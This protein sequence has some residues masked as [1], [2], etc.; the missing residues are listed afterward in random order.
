MQST[1]KYHVLQR[2]LCVRSNIP[3][4]ASLF[5]DYDRCQ[6]HRARPSMKTDLNLGRLQDGCEALLQNHA[7][8]FNFQLLL[9]LLLVLVRLAKGAYVRRLVHGGDVQQVHDIAA[10]VYVV[11]SPLEGLPAV[12]QTQAAICSVRRTFII[13]CEVHRRCPGPFQRCNIL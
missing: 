6:L 5:D 13:P 2:D 3:L 12:L 10:S 7:R 4:V 1:R 9:V 8:V 11:Q